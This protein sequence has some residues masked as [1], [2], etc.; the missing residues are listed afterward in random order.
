MDDAVVA[1]I[2][3]TPQELRKWQVCFR[4]HLI[5]LH[6]YLHKLYICMY[7][8]IYI[9]M[10]IYT[11]HMGTNIEIMCNYFIYIHMHA[12]IMTMRT[13]NTFVSPQTCA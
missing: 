1:T 3:Q 6:P 5:H 12:K 8:Y 2:I 10:Y 11:V 9:Y 13:Y 4:C 7:I